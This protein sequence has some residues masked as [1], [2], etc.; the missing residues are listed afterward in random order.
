MAS[1][2]PPKTVALTPQ[3]QAVVDHDHGPALVFAVAGAGKTT[4]MVQRIARLVATGLFP[5]E[6]ILA[7]SFARANVVDLRQ[8]LTAWPAC[9]AV[10]VRTLHA[11]G[12]DIIRKAQAQ[13]YL[14]PTQRRHSWRDDP[15]FDMAQLSYRILGLTLQAAR[16]RG[17]PYQHEL[18]G[19]D[20]QDFLD[21]VGACKN[22]LTFADLNQVRLPP[23]AR[24][25]V[26]QAQPP[27]EA[28][29][30]Y[31]PLYQL[32]EEVRRQKGWI[33]FDDML[34]TA[35]E[36]LVQQ[37][38]LLAAVQQAYRCVLV[39]E[40]QDINLVQSEL[41]DLI[42]RPHGNYM[43]IGDDD[44]TIYEWRGAEPRFILAF[45]KRYKAQVYVIDDNFRCP[46]A[47]LTLAN[48]VIRH[49]QKR[50][51]KRLNLTQGFH[52]ETAVFFDQDAASMSRAIVG[53]IDALRA[54]GTPLNDVAVLVRLNAQTPHIEQELIAR[55]IPYRVSKPFYERLEIKTLIDY[56]RLAWLEREMRR[57]GRGLTNAR[58]QET[59]SATWRN[60]CN[61]PKRY[62]TNQL[63][64]QIER[65]VTQ[66]AQPLSAAVGVA[67]ARADDWLSAI[68]DDLSEDLAWLADS[69][70]APADAV[71]RELETR[72]GYKNF[73][74]D[75]SG[76]PQT[77]EGRAVGVDVFIA[78]AAGQGSLLA[79]MQHVRAL[80]AQKVGQA[81]TE[82]A[83]TLATIHQ[84]KGLE[85][86]VVFVPQCNAEIMPFKGEEAENLE[87]ERRLFY[88]ALTRS[89]A[90][91]YLHVTT[92]EDVSPFL[93]EAQWETTL[94]A[95]QRVRLALEK[96]PAQWQAA[97]AL[98]L[99]R[100][101]RPLY[102]ERY[103]TRWWGL[104]APAEARAA[105]AERMAAFLTA[106]AHRGYLDRLELDQADV[107]FWRALAPQAAP[108][109]DFPGLE[110]ILPGKKHQQDIA[111]AKTSARRRQD[112]P[113]KKDSV[114]ARLNRV[115]AAGKDGGETAVTELVNAL[116][117]PVSSVR[118]VARTTLVRMGGTAVLQA[119]LAFL[120][121]TSNPEGR[122]KPRARAEAALAALADNP[123]EAAAVRTQA[124]RAMEDASK[125]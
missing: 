49:N 122:A 85:W 104:R 99:A 18:N 81:A 103:F 32:Y 119:L 61:R 46:A 83:V 17:V 107:D 90:H 28:L 2:S 94:P 109:R 12:L 27:S 118:W 57:N 20:R 88:V 26:T 75:A 21:Y 22:Q 112:A 34:V 108:A 86:P 95:L 38:E 42:A 67:A 44:Q 16:Q 1:S 79:F 62:L 15:D 6:S 50:Q 52:G 101:V 43:A 41:L 66:R 5:P 69:L 102:L 25:I 93:T 30:W 63:R 113:A 92:D 76:F 60:V 56:C 89:R 33:T 105:M 121:A 35:W 47:P 120:A 124:R 51:P 4:A 65:T 48:Q 111:R 98:A 110:A 77:G 84:A 106:V 70:D 19:L 123:A 13:G 71:L 55:R 39:D 87:E 73:L 117:D 78:Y 97:D 64:D 40:F 100:A 9:R 125:D 74:R 36:L 14:P 115:L 24:R 114:N 72:L 91:L 53:R 68:L 11:L 116:A 96:P 8:A 31:L 54:A 80:A 10:D 37:P 59:F 58:V 82:D 45:A 23:A 29:H 3:Q 7:A